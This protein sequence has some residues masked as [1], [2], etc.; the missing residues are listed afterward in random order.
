MEGRWYCDGEAALAS[1]IIIIKSYSAIINLS[2]YLPPPPALHCI[3]LYRAYPRISA[4]GGTIFFRNKSKKKG[5]KT[6]EKEKGII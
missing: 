2:V 3:S 6:Q 4:R 1:R 5:N